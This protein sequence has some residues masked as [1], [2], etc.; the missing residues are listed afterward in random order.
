MRRSVLLSWLVVGA[1]LSLISG[2]GL[3]AS[4]SDT[5]RTG[6][7][8]VDTQALQGSADLKIATASYTDPGVGCEGFSDDLTSPLIEF[9][10]QVPGAFNQDGYYYCLQNAG[11]QTVN[12]TATAVEVTD[13]ELACTGDEDLYDTS[14]SVPD[15]GELSSVVRISFY[16]VNCVDGT[17]DTPPNAQDTVA[18]MASV[19]V[20]FGTLSPA[21]TRCFRSAV[22]T[23]GPPN[24]VQASQTDRVTWRFAFTGAV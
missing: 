15:V 11:S 4:L 12:L 3:F 18:H 1:A 10:N 14:C 20:T 22:F 16:G 24:V 21:T 7:N 5:A 6:T 8:V 17:D 9:T 19:P 23:N 2:T 13:T